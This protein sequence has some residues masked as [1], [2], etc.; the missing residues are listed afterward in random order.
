MERDDLILN[1]GALLGQCERDVQEW[2]VWRFFP[3]DDDYGRRV[4][5]MLGITA[6]D[7]RGPPLLP[8]HVL[9]DKVKRQLQNLGNNND[10]I[11]PNVWG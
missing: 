9:T 1:M 5:E 7:V 2:M 6:A 11:D 8:K 10:R 3:V 4:G